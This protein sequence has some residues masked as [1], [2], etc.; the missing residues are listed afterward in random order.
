MK[1]FLKQQ[2]I[3]IIFT[4]I[5]AFAGILYWHF[6]GCS[7]GTCPLTSHWYTSFLFGGL[8]GYLIG[9][10]LKDIRKKREKK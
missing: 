7:T 10:I 2:I 1:D 4:A 8:A 9:D 3:S 6:I 5:G